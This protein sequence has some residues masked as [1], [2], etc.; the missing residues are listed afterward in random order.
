MNELFRIASDKR[1]DWDYTFM[2]S[3]TEI[4]NEQVHDL[5]G[6]KPE[7]RLDIKQGA[8]GN[9]VQGLT[10][11]QVENT[12]RMNQVEFTVIVHYSLHY[13]CEGVCHGPQKQSN[14]SNLNEH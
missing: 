5:L 6:S 12:E 9:F 1:G 8:Q 13:C 4:Y 14:C 11:L 10:W 7:A 3:M 2:V